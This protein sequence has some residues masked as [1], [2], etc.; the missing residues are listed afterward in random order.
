MC[1]YVLGTEAKATDMNGTQDGVLFSISSKCSHWCQC[2]HDRRNPS[3]FISLLP[4]P[5]HTPALVLLLPLCVF[6]TCPATFFSTPFI[7]LFPYIHPLPCF[8]PLSDMPPNSILS[9]LDWL[10]RMMI[11]LWIICLLCCQN[12]YKYLLQ[13]YNCSLSQGYNVCHQAILQLKHSLQHII[14]SCP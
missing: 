2:S 12:N 3:R 14:I 6:N 13:L 1:V 5:L 4:P 11:Q 10:V 9:M 8:F 7:L